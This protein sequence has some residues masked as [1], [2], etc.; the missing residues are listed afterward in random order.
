[1]FVAFGDESFVATS[2]THF[3]VFA[4]V[5]IHR[6]QLTNARDFALGSCI[7]PGARFHFH[8]ESAPRRRLL[9]EGLRF[10]PWEARTL[11]I[12]AQ[13]DR[14]ERARRLLLTA[15]HANDVGDE[16]ILERRGIRQDRSDIDLVEA[17]NQRMRQQAPRVRHLSSE[18]E[19]LLWV[20]D[21]FAGACASALAG[22]T[23][24]DV[25]FTLL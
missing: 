4:M 18:H 24:F 19:P 8:A 7:K 10:G 20:A 13:A 16:W 1:M 21:V 5:A 14:Q 2:T 25:P 17:L 11:A 15:H 9:T 6:D 23:D 12:Q 3:Y 22:R